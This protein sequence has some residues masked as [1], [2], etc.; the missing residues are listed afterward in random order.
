MTRSV[1]VLIH[2]ILANGVDGSTEAPGM[3]RSVGS[4]P[5]GLDDD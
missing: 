1:G 4:S 5:V 2:I 3:S